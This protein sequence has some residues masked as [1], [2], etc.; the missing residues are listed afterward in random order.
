MPEERG[1]ALRF[2]AAARQAA[3]E[4]G[5]TEAMLH[6]VAALGKVDRVEALGLM[7]QIEAAAKAD[8]SSARPLLLALA[9]AVQPWEPG[10]A[11]RLAHEAEGFPEEAVERRYLAR[12]AV[13]NTASK[14]PTQTEE[15]V[16]A[17]GLIM[18]ERD[19]S[20]YL[21][22][23]IENYGP[24]FPDWC[25]KAARAIPD[26]AE[27]STALHRIAYEAEGDERRDLLAEALQA[28]DLVEDENEGAR[29]RVYLASTA[30]E[31]DP[32]WA[33][34]ILNATADL[35][36]KREA[37]LAEFVPAFAAQDLEAGLVL[38]SAFAPSR[39]KVR[40]L[41]DIAAGVR[42]EDADRAAAIWEGAL[43]QAKG[44]TDP[45]ERADALFAAALGLADVDPLRAA[46]LVGRE[47]MPLLRSREE[48][49]ARGVDEP[50]AWAA[51]VTAV[52]RQ[53]KPEAVKVLECGAEVCGKDEVL[54]AAVRQVGAE[55]LEFAGTLAEEI[56]SPREKALA[57]THLA[58]VALQ[59]AGG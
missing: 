53:S 39:E 45:T 50:E 59:G 20:L 27:R 21:R 37:F 12:Q 46:R 7:Q 51:L 34:A 23:T 1:T 19:L 57:L 38:A 44:I 54:T 15:A 10:Q 40:V 11:E 8:L 5:Q 14:L 17:L 32:D 55:D 9:G 28:A 47:A 2:A 29:H 36:G 13:Q 25:L 41:S 31:D 33:F 18:D 4:A 52:A 6:L 30:V 56:E 26:P 24:A 48:E 58:V 16:G 22:Q 49:E 3:A 42:D 43:A 35:G